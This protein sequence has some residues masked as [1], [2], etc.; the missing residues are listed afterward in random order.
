[1]GDALKKHFSRSSKKICTIGI[2]PW[3]VIENRNDLIGR[4][5]SRNFALSHSLCGVF[6]RAAHLFWFRSPASD[7]R[8]VS[9]AAESA[10][11]I[12]RSQQSS[13]PFP[14]GGRRDRGQVWRRGQPATAAGETHQPPENPRA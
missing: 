7:C 10:Q 13:F 9:D 14:P 3:G 11:Q 1:M 4:D 5:V 6:V 2:A 8:S 12:K